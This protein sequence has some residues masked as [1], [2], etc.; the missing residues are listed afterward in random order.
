MKDASEESKSR[1]KRS[2]A[3]LPYKAR[4]E[5]CA[6]L[7]RRLVTGALGMKSRAT[8]DVL[9]KERRILQEARGCFFA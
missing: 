3:V 7:A 4:P 6:S 5:T 9:E 8:K 1:A 2:G